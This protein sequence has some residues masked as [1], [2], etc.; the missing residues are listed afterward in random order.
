M[1]EVPQRVEGLLRAYLAHRGDPAESFHDFASAPSTSQRA[2]G[3]RRAQRWR[4]AN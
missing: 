3:A 2:E 4:M 1:S